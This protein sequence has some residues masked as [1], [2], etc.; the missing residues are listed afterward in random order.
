MVSLNRA[1]LPIYL[2]HQSVLVITT[3]AATALLGAPAPGLLTAPAG[4]V[5]VVQRLAWLPLLAVILA[6][7]TAPRWWTTRRAR[8]D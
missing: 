7:A 1:A 6:V 3:A 5:W 2:G 8:G 4:P